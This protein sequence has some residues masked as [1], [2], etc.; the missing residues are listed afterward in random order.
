MRVT[1]SMTTTPGPVSN[2]LV[3]MVTPPGGT[4][5]TLHWFLPTAGD[6]SG[7]AGFFAADTRF[8]SGYRIHINGRDPILLTSAATHFFA[9]RYEFANPEMFDHEGAIGAS[10]ISIR[11]DRTIA[12]GVHEDLDIVSYALRPVS[13][14]ID[15]EID[16][17]FADI[18][19]VIEPRLVRRGIIQSRWYSSR[20]ELRTTYTNR[21][22][23]RTLVARMIAPRSAVEKSSPS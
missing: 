22:F 17:D 4:M 2:A 14:A 20:R 13:L 15:I 10:T 3:E 18:F 9:S 16:S 8:V 6:G 5:V 1:P 12:D 7:S 19:D 23:R 11:L 21:E